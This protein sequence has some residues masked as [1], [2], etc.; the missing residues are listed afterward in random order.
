[1]CLSAAPIQHRRFHQNTAY[2]IQH[3]CLCR[4]KYFAEEEMG[5]FAFENS[6]EVL[7]WLNFVLDRPADGGCF[8][9]FVWTII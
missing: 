2:F 1:M 5:G 9:C 8:V 6:S 4:Y 7:S 3:P